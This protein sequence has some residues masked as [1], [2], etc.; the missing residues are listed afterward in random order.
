[1]SCSY[2]V[3]PHHATLTPAVRRYEAL[4]QALVFGK[5]SWNLDGSTRRNDALDALQLG[6]RLSDGSVNVGLLTESE[7]FIR[8]VHDIIRDFSVSG[9]GAN[10]TALETVAALQNIIQ[11]DMGSFGRSTLDAVQVYREDSESL[12]ETILTTDLLVSVMHVL[13]V[14]TL[15]IV[16]FHRM[17]SVLMRQVRDLLCS[18]TLQCSVCACVCACVRD[19]MCGE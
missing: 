15:Y 6:S 18:A 12:T 8:S 7:W 2:M 14:L 5:S 16:V 10:Q 11:R 13:L 17:V 1:V 3:E 4:Y 9:L 19:T